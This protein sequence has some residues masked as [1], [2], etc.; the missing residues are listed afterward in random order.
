MHR[1]P[2]QIQNHHLIIESIGV[3][4]YE[5]V[6]NA[7]T[8]SFLSSFSIQQPIRTNMTRLPKTRNFIVTMLVTTFAF[9]V[10]IGLSIASVTNEKDTIKN[11]NIHSDLEA[12]ITAD[13]ED[14]S[15]SLVKRT[16]VPEA[17]RFR[18]RQRQL[19]NPS[20]G[21]KSSF[22]LPDIV[23]N[24]YSAERWNGTWISDIEFAYRNRQGDLSLLRYDL[25]G[26][27]LVCKFL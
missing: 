13:F 22:S 1:S 27:I 3:Q 9:A 2:L 6:R 17:Q 10:L 26:Y 16:A 23:N 19:N 5:Q 7:V 18:P 8:L 21:L 12:D 25:L 14:E 20:A 24:E 15:L 4:N 11:I